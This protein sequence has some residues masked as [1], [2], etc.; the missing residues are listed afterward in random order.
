MNKTEIAKLYGKTTHDI[1]LHYI[2]FLML[3]AICYA[4]VSKL[5]HLITPKSTL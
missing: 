3:Y 4:F 5:F 1:I 2:F